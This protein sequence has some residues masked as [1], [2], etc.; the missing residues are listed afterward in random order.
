MSNQLKFVEKVEEMIKLTHLNEIVERHCHKYTSKEILK[1]IDNKILLVLEKARK[2][3]ERPKR[4]IPF[5]K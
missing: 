5:S 1:S 2:F 3:V 4:S